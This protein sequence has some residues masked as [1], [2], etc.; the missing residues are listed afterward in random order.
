MCESEFG[1]LDPLSRRRFF[2]D[3]AWNC[4][5][6]D[7]FFAGRDVGEQFGLHAEVLRDDRFGDM[8]E[9]ICEEESRVFGEVAV[10]EDEK[11]LGALGTET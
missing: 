5:L 4:A 7:V 8:S 3:R 10:V 9:P 11:E 2:F 1:F 6:E